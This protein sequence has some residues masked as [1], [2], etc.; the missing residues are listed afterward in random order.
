MSIAASLGT[1]SEK[2]RPV[3]AETFIN[4][5]LWMGT[6][7]QEVLHLFDPNI[8]NLK[9]EVKENGTSECRLRF[10]NQSNVVYGGSPFY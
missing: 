1:F 7:S 3:G 6:P 10:R 8:S 4:P 5:P 9:I 2:L